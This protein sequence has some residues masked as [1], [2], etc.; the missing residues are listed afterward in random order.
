MKRCLCLAT[1]ILAGCSAL[2]AADIIRSRTRSMVERNIAAI[3]NSIVKQNTNTNGNSTTNQTNMWPTAA[4]TV[5]PTNGATNAVFAFNA[6]SSFDPDGTI[7]SNYWDFNG[8]GLFEVK[9]ASNTYAT[10]FTNAAGTYAVVLKVIDSAGAYG[11]TTN[12]VMV[13]AVNP[14]LI[15]WNKLESAASLS[16]SVVG[17]NGWFTGSSSNYSFTG[18]KYNNGL[19]A[20]G[21]FDCSNKVVFPGSVMSNRKQCIE[22]WYKKTGTWQAGAGANLICY[23]IPGSPSYNIDAHILTGYSGVHLLEFSYAGTVMGTS[24]HDTDIV[25]NQNYHMAFVWDEDGI[26]GGS[27]KMRVYI[28]G[29]LVGSTNTANARTIVTNQQFVVGDIHAVSGWPEWCAQGVIDNLKI[30]NY[31]KTDFS[32]RFTE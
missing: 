19:Q 1:L 5:S 28:D 15:L 14:G 3:T 26:G 20:V 30:F 29:V 8:D 16:N 25:S 2:S 21:F 10:N 13:Y 11:I 17:A 27:D 23:G 4:F 18:G 12:Q 7:V 31:A 9:V 6:S 24:V 32:D 22:F